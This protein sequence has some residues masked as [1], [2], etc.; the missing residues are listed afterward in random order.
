MFW[1]RQKKLI[2]IALKTYEIDFPNNYTSRTFLWLTV[3]L[4]GCFANMVDYYC[5]PVDRATNGVSKDI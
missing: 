2:D 3:L 5:T 1:I 4:R